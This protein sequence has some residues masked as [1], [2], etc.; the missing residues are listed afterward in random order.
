MAPYLLQPDPL[1]K[2]INRIESLHIF[3]QSPFDSINCTWRHYTHPTNKSVAIYCCHTAHFYLGYCLDR[4]SVSRF[5]CS[6]ETRYVHILAILNSTKEFP[7][8]RMKKALNMKELLVFQSSNLH[9][10]Q[11]VRATIPSSFRWRNRTARK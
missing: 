6:A 4:E 2:W 3:A 8:C 11:C 5:H 7:V 10:Y 1:F 9:C